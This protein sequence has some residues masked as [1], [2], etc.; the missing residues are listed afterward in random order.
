MADNTLLTTFLKNT[1]STS[2]VIERLLL[3]K[4]SLETRF[5]NLQPEKNPT[6]SREELDWLNSLG[7][8]FY[9]HFTKLNS[10]EVLGGLEK[11]IKKISKITIYLTCILPVEEINRLGIWIRKNVSG[12]VLLEIKLDQSLIAGCA[13]SFNGVYR[14]YSLRARIEKSKGE[15]LESLKTYL[16]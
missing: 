16:K 4:Q 1:Y 2:Q 13:L 14:D 15:I 7:E 12:M 8:D 11:D 10:Y 3:L 6:A 5:F 9:Q